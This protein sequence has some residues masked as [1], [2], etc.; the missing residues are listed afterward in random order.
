MEKCEG[1][2]LGSDKAL[3][4]NCNLFGIKWP[5]QFRYLGIDLGHNQ[6]LND[7]KNFDEK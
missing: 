3:Q 5:E 7:I 4:L 1:F 2:W 6:K